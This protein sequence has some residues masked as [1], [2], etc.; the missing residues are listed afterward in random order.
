MCCIVCQNFQSFFQSLI[1]RNT[2]QTLPLSIVQNVSSVRRPQP[3]VPD[4][5]RESFNLSELSE[6]I[7]CP[8]ADNEA[9]QRH[10]PPNFEPI[11]QPKHLPEPTVYTSSITSRT[12]SNT[13]Q[14]G[15]R[16]TMPLESSSRNPQT[17]SKKVD[18]G[19]KHVL[20]PPSSFVRTKKSVNNPR[21]KNFSR[22][23]FFCE[24]SPGGNYHI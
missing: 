3:R 1:S 16:E 9:V 12:S 20:L 19:K 2:S 7:T 18:L 4:Y 6:H 22:G 17:F 11:T 14:T 23:M 21:Q 24:I 5:L 10:L 13:S 15:L 8:A